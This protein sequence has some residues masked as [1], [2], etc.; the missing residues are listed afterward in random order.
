M[1]NGNAEEGR[2]RGTKRGTLNKSVKSPTR[3]QR[4]GSVSKMHDSS[5]QMNGST[6][7]GKMERA[8]SELHIMRRKDGTTPDPDSGEKKK[9]RGKSPFR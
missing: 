5:S 1:V 9:N 2:S 4:A 6:G 7:H 8:A 3:P